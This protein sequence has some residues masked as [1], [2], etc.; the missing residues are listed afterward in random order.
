MGE[1]WK[2]SGVEVGNAVFNSFTARYSPMQM[3]SGGGHAEGGP[4][5]PALT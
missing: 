1:L 4:S 3:H 5:H 2:I